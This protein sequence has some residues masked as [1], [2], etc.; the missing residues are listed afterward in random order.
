M[1]RSMVYKTKYTAL[2]NQEVLALLQNPRDEMI[3]TLPALSPKH[4]DIYLYSYKGRPDAKK[5]WRADQIRWAHMGV[6]SL[7]KK[8]PK[9]VKTYHQ[10]ILCGKREKFFRY[11]YESTDKRIGLVVVHYLGSDREREGVHDTLQ[12]FPQCSDDRT[13]P[14][15]LE[16]VDE[17]FVNDPGVSCRE[18]PVDMSDFLVNMQLPES[19]GQLAHKLSSEKAKSKLMRDDIYGV[20][21]LRFALDNFIRNFTLLPELIIVVSLPKIVD[22]YNEVCSINQHQLLSYDTTF[23]IGDYYVSPIVFKCPWFKGQ[24]SIPLAA[25]I[26]DNGSA[27]VHKTFFNIL[28]DLTVNFNNADIRLVTSREGAIAN[29]LDSV[30]PEITH[31]LRWDHILK[32]VE[33]WVS[34]HKSRADK[35]DYV[36]HVRHLL[37]S[38]SESLFHKLYEGYRQEW[39][40]PF[41]L[42]FDENIKSDLVY[43]SGRWLLN[44]LRI[45]TPGSGVVTNVSDSMNIVLKKLTAW[46]EVNLEQM[47]LALYFL[48][49][50]Y[51]KEVLRGRCGTGNY[52]LR[53]PYEHLAMDSADIAFTNDYFYLPPDD[54]IAF[55]ENKSWTQ[56]QN[57]DG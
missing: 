48:Q 46:K 38:D 35:M 2:T 37:E 40:E 47:V 44:E 19:V 17:R 26:Y 52:H 39:S 31:V 41:V 8:D 27:E 18:E 24:P 1:P 16:N 4:G 28:N 12:S 34:G 6:H 7:P 43:K 22:L 42:Y 10:K 15:S 49:T 5:D 45:Y 23:T 29:A 21:E 20:Y 14:T 32:E 50:F 33:S 53:K 11:G 13:L 54:I 57:V 9:I 36:S 3:S 55:L 51:L 56:K 25:M 30:V